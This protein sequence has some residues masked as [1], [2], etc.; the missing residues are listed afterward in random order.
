MNEKFLN[1]SRNS[2]ECKDKLD[3]GFLFKDSTVRLRRHVYK[4]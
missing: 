1:C 2:G 3:E 4:Q